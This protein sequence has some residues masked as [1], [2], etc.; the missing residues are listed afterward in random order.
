M[1][2]RGARCCGAGQRQAA[3]TDGGATENTQ[4]FGE[5]PQRRPRYFDWRP[6][7]VRMGS[8]ELTCSAK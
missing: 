7:P 4:A 6:D 1:P 8:S 3:K 2:R 5:L